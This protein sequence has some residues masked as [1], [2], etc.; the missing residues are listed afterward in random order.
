MCNMV[1]VA[2]GRNVILIICQEESVCVWQLMVE[3]KII[4]ILRQFE[5]PYIVL[6][7]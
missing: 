4:T 6:G 5:F 3:T 1:S 7:R 2:G